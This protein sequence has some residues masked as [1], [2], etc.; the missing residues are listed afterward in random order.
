MFLLG[1]G[2]FYFDCN[3][4]CSCTIKV[5]KAHIDLPKRHPLLVWYPVPQPLPDNCRPMPNVPRPRL[6]SALVFSHVH[7]PPNALS[8]ERNYN[9]NDRS[10]G[11]LYRRRTR[12]HPN[13]RACRRS[14]RRGS[15][16]W[17]QRYRSSSRCGLRSVLIIPFGPLYAYVCA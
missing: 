13:L 1:S 15:T 5:K 9:P 6:F 4:D 2:G 17:S 12:H 3:D 7:A 8:S 16:L 10:R 14:W 11:R